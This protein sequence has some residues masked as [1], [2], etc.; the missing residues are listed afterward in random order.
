[1]HSKCNCSLTSGLTRVACIRRPR[2]KHITWTP[3]TAHCVDL[4]IEDIFKLDYFAQPLLRTRELITFINNHHA[5]LALLKS[6][7]NKGLLKPGETRFATAIIML[8]RALDVCEALGRMVLSEE[9]SNAVKRMRA[10][11]RARADDVYETAVSRAHWARVKQV[12]WPC[13]T[14]LSNARKA[15]L[16]QLHCC[17]PELASLVLHLAPPQIVTVCT[18]LVK[19]LRLADGSAPV[20]G[21]IHFNCYKVQE[22]IEQCDLPSAEK[23]AVAKIW[24]ERWT[25]LQ[26]PMHAAGYC[27]DPQ[28]VDDEGCT[29]DPDP[30]FRGLVGIIG[31]LL[32]SE[33]KR[34]AALLQYVT[35]KS[36]EGLFG[37]KEAWEM[38]DQVPAHQWWHI[39]GRETRELQYVAMRVLSQCSS[40][41]S[42][43]RSWSSYSFIHSKLRNRLTPARAEALVYV[44]TNGRLARKQSRVTAE[45]P[46]VGWDEACY[47]SSDDSEWEELGDDE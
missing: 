45:E 10:D 33:A 25:Q 2:F 35:Y 7:S 6:M 26:S 24:S 39:W 29:H 36:K 44:F 37:L 46:F 41:C 8:Q 42:C 11:E 1:M 40:S 27:L 43:E 16:L 4:A 3:C 22:S 20:V 32:D 31:K 17:V 5:T 47:E 21:K 13:F 38:A 30:S 19:L 18:P 14:C 9:W 12:G 28:F 15:R 34:S 23:E